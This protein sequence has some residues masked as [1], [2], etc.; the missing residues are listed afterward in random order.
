MISL[1][2]IHLKYGDEIIFDDAQI[3]IHQSK[4]TSVIGKS[5]S[6]KTSILN[7]I[8]LIADHTDYQYSYN[9][10]S[11]DV[12]DERRKSQLRS[13]HFL[14]IHQNVA[15]MEHMTVLENM[16]LFSKHA[17]LS[18][19]TAQS[20]L[21]KVHLNLDLKLAAKKLSKGQKQRLLI[22]AALISDASVLILDEPTSALDSENKKNLLDLIKDIAQSKHLTVIIATHDAF[23]QEYS[24]FVYQIENHK[25]VQVSNCAA[26]ELLS[27]VSANNRKSNF[28]N[29]LMYN[30]SYEKNHF[31]VTFLLLLVSA[32][33]AGF[34]AVFV[35][36]GT[37]VFSQWAHRING[38]N[39]EITLIKNEQEASQ[40]KSFS[41]EEMSCINMIVNDA[42]K[43]RPFY[44]FESVCRD[45]K[46]N[47]YNFDCTLL[48]HLTSESF[49]NLSVQPYLNEEIIREELCLQTS[50][51]GG[52]YI[53]LEVADTLN[54]DLSENDKISIE[55]VF[56]VLYN[57]QIEEKETGEIRQYVTGKEL[58]LENLQISGILLN[59]V[60][61][62]YYTKDN[63]VV[64][65]AFEDIS[66]IY[67]QL[68]SD[69]LN[70]ALSV[71][72]KSGTVLQ[73]EK[74]RPSAYIYDG[75]L[76][77]KEQ[78][79][80]LEISPHISVSMASDGYFQMLKETTQSLVSGILLIAG[81]EI[82]A[83]ILMMLAY[84]YRFRSRSKEIALLKSIGYH[85]KEINKTMIIDAFIKAVFIFFTSMIAFVIYQNT[86]FQIAD[87][88]LMVFFA[89]VLF[90]LIPVFIPTIFICFKCKKSQ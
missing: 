16:K 53:P 31:F 6:G 46:T 84:V 30:L 86:L 55:K 21:E 89:S 82:I 17:H 81:V 66:D 34:G 75:I 7:M 14:F 54:I 3:D 26:D 27:D 43:L 65:M 36:V 48:Y 88:H 5:G 41:E 50:E 49:R 73:I 68:F 80:L 72:E 18:N 78:Q 29:L 23:V 77:E 60:S 12:S 15:L 83:S 25:I 40:F 47:K 4:V 64:Y 56:A 37:D 19:A 67:H 45:L 11:V 38:V 1:S 57:L 10:E 8:G 52:I 9:D 20:A 63:Y 85:Y 44:R 71:F 87:Y 2:N 32:M 28:K 74:V 58:S 33:I 42:E 24:D 69:D 22:A 39:Q 79:Q 13:S 61:D 35:S 76:S 59:S 51:P 70:Q 90:S 62:L